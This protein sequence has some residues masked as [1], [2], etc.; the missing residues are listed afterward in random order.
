MVQFI[1]LSSILKKLLPYIVSLFTLVYK[2]GT[3]DR[4]LRGNSGMDWGHPIQG[5]VVILS[6]A[7]C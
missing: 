1:I 3:G 5:G 6:V 4:I 7:S 2:M